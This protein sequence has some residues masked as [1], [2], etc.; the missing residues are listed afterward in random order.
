MKPLR[1]PSLHSVRSAIH[2]ALLVDEGGSAVDDARV[3]YWRHAIGG[4]ISPSDLELGQSLLI[5]LGLALIEEGNLRL[6]PD[7]LSLLEGSMEEAIAVICSRALQADADALVS[8]AAIEPQLGVVLSD[9]STR[10]E[11]LL[12]LGRRFDDAN[13]RLVG[14]VGEMVVVSAAREELRA[15]G[16]PDLARRVR[17]LSLRSDQLGYDVTAPRV[18]GKNRLLEVKAARDISSGTATVFLTRN[19]MDVGLRYD[20]WSL[21]VCQVTDVAAREGSVIGWC[22]RH[23]LSNLLPIDIAGGAKW[24]TC[25]LDLPIKSLMLGLPPPY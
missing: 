21:V 11:M 4:M 24:E 15:L 12:S 2:V 18:N 22:A 8:V 17:R 16:F 9:L 6:T 3:S 5:E 20:E 19:E 7:T 14:E 13:R 23:T 1:L 10:E 25:E